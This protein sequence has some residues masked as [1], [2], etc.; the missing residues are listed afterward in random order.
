MCVCVYVCVCVC[1]QEMDYELE[2]RNTM[3]FK[4]HMASLEGV[5]V[6]TVYPELTSRKIIVTEWIEVRACMGV[7]VCTHACARAHTHSAVSQS[8]TAL[9]DR[10]AHNQGA[11]VCVYVCVCVQGQR[12]AESSAEDVRA[13]CSTLLN[14]YLIQL[15]ETGLLHADPHP[16]THTH[17]N[18]HPPPPPPPHTHPCSL[19]PHI[20]PHT[21]IDR[22]I[23]GQTV[24]RLHEWP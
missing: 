9:L 7:C 15:L 14:C 8:A 10:Y 22:Q 3:T 5:K 1:P 23:N 12:L 24:C 17:T 21:V 20:T 6:A 4:K 13:L 2:A 19:V 16:G 11:Y 18:T